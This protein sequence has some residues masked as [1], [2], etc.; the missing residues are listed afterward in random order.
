MI[1]R[2]AALYGIEAHSL[3]EV[4]DNLARASTPRG[5]FAVKTFVAADIERAER[6]AALLAHLA[7]EPA[8]YR[9]PI[10]VR[11]VDG[12]A[13]YSRAGYSVYDGHQ[14]R[15]W[16]RFVVSR[17][18]VVLEDGQVTAAQGRGQRLLMDPTAAP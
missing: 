16:P 7:E 18:D 3:V 13:H 17:G 10:L 14:V 9:V 4:T 5:D 15:G 11:T 12:A 6:E 2:F 1:P 8:G